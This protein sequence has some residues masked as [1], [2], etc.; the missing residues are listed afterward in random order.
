MS[1]V[2]SPSFKCVAHH[3][4]KLYYF[5]VVFLKLCARCSILKSPHSKFSE[6]GDLEMIS[7]N[8]CSSG[9]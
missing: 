3:T 4:Q 5:A 1:K 6:G 9:N 8:F 7:I 2:I